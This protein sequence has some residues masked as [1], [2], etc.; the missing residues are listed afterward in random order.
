MLSAELEAKVCR[1]LSTGQVHIRW[2]SPENIC[3]TVQG[4]SGIYEVCLHNGRWRCSCPAWHG[5]S[6]LEAV[7]RVTA[8]VVHLVPA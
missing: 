8:P 7:T 5:C 4:D 2:V 1:L 3:A 6:H